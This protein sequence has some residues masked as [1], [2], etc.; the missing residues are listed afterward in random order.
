[1]SSLVDYSN[2]MTLAAK[3]SKVQQEMSLDRDKE[4]T[5]QGKSA[6]Y[7]YSYVTEGAIMNA[8]REKLCSQNVAVFVSCSAVEREDNLTCAEIEV[9]LRSRGLQTR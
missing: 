2:K 9:K 8:V 4:V 1:M 5:I 6:K 7:S 3:I